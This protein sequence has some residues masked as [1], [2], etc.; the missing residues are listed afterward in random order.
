MRPKPYTSRSPA[1]HV[2]KLGFEASDVEIESK[3]F[4]QY[5]ITVPEFVFIGYEDLQFETITKDGGF[6]SFLTEDID[7]AKVV[8]EIITPEK[9]SQQIEDNQET[10]RA[11]V[12]D[13]Y[14][15]IDSELDDGIKIK[16]KFKFE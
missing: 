13:F 12:I 10:L 15:G 14:T 11:E 7:T 9:Q 5:V 6:L 8:T 16:L 3:W 1:T 4:N 2:S